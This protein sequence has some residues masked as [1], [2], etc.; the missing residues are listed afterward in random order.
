M[1]AA[2]GSEFHSLEEVAD[3]MLAVD[4]TF[5]PNPEEHSHYLELYSKFCELMGEQGYGGGG[6]GGGMKKR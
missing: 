2:L 1:I 6:A 3:A 4:A 5:F